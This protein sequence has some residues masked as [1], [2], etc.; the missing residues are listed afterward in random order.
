MEDTESFLDLEHMKD[1]L[2]KYTRV[3]ERVCAHVRFIQFCVNDLKLLHNR[4][5]VSRNKAVQYKYKIKLSVM[6]GIKCYM[7]DY[8]CE[9][10]Q[11][12]SRLRYRLRVMQPMIDDIDSPSDS[13]WPSDD[14]TDTSY[15]PVTDPTYRLG[16]SSDQSARLGREIL[17]HGA[18]PESGSFILPSPLY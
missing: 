13:E 6:M 5:I 16:D 12:M 15:E 7:H 2:D 3:F 17:G 18:S 14:D 9:K 10:A 8:A 1:L 4:A 11:Q